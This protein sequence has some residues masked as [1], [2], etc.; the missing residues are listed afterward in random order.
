MQTIPPASRLMARA[1]ALLL[2]GIVTLAA[3]VAAFAAPS[4]LADPYPATAPQPDAVTFTVNGGAPQACVLTA[5]A[6]GLQPRCDLAGL[7]A[8]TYT[9]VMTA[10]RAAGCQGSTCW[11]AGSASSAPF[12]Y[13]RAA[14]AVAAPIGLGLQ[15]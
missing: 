7:T 3:S 2:V 6:G 13:T 10:S 14:S 12:S 5:V 15:P 4:L 1:F 8:G 11:D 9:L